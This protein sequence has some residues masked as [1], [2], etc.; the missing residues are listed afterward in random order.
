[1]SHGPA[2][3]PA[4]R[5]A[6]RSVRAMAAA[7]GGCGA[8]DA[9]NNVSSGEAPGGLTRRQLH[10]LE[11]DRL[12]PCALRSA[13]AGRRIPL[14]SEGRALDFRTEFQRDR[15]RIVHSRAFRRLRQKTQVYLP[16]RDDHLR[17]R[18]LHTLEVSGIART[19]SR[20][21]AL[22][23]DLAESI[24]LAHDMGHCAFG[25]AGETLL[26]EILTGRCGVPAVDPAAARQAGGFKHNYQSL[27]VVD[28]LE[29]R[30]RHP[31]LNLTDPVR[32]GI[33]KHTGMCSSIRYPDFDSRGLHLDR[34]PFLEAQ[35]VALADEMAQQVHD[36][37]DGLQD[38]AVDLAAVE[39]LGLV[40]QVIGKL[41]SGYPSPSR[42]MRVNQIIRGAAHLLVASVVTWSSRQIAVWM[43]KEKIEGHEDFL[44]RIDRIPRNLVV[45]AP[46]VR[47]LYGE[48]KRFVRRRIINSQQVNRTDQRARHCLSRLFATYFQQPLLLPNHLLL[49]FK[50]EEGGRFLRDCSP[51]GRE[52]EIQTHFRK[53]P[54]FLRLLAD[55]LASM[56]DTY[57]L[58]EYSRLHHPE[59]GSG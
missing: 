37:D 29:K 40:K 32:E 2:V 10:A 56:T 50:E 30:Y 1:M 41:G 22:N 28:R 38:G 11:E 47:G 58:A 21:L 23:E 55:H 4:R 52:K 24:A 27:R 54:A 13:R 34:P 7:R 15:D 26:D 33:L 42:F 6:A 3:P 5:A 16:D 35:V 44:E 19:I 46:P 51:A 59:A 31:G 36:L 43:D 49:R 20:A 18:L 48:L 14:D 53:N 57:A 9:E 45:L 25:H 39:A 12:S 8:G 17:N